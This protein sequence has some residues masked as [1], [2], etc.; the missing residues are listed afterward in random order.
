MGWIILVLIPKGNT[1][2]WGVLLLETLWKVVEAIVGNGL[3]EII[4]F[5]DVI[6][7]FRAGRVMETAILEL[8]LSQ[9]LDSINQD[10]LL[11]VFLYL[12]KIYDNANRGHILTTL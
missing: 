4:S 2:T 10:P 9:D 11:M 5:H 3:R 6:H 12:C 1:N 8:K 7:G